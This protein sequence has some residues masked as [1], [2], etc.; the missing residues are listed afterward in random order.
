MLRVQ[1]DRRVN[2]GLP[3]AGRLVGKTE[4]QIQVAVLEPRLTG[5]CEGLSR[6]LGRVDATDRCQMVVVERLNA[7]ADPVEPDLPHS[8]KRLP[9]DGARVRFDAPLRR[10]LK[11]E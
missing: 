3:L 9:G 11:P 2:I 10:G 8:L 5:P 1:P 6:L 4:D 7:Q